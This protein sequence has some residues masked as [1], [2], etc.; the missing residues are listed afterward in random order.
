MY[1]QII[2]ILA[3]QLQ[4]DPAKISEDTDIVEDLGAD[5]LD[6]VEMLMDLEQA[7]SLQVPDEKIADFRTPKDIFAYIAAHKKG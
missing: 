4:I 6:I 2:E 3:K 5:S 1:E 7:F